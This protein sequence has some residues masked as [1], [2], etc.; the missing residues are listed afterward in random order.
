MTPLTL[1]LLSTLAAIGTFVVISATAVAA[2]IQLRHLRGSNQLVALNEI[3]EVVDSKEFAAAR[4]FVQHELP[5]LMRD[6]GFAE[7]LRAPLVDDTLHPLSLVGNL[8]ENLGTYVKY[9]IIDPD[10]ACD[11]LGGVVLSTWTSLYP[12]VIIRRQTT[13]NLSALWENFEYLAVLSED[14]AA[15]HPDGAY[16]KGVRRMRPPGSTQK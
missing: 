5:V 8:F 2:I 11:V 9:G 3:G 16:P 12:V 4:Q 15:R 6:P 13:E 1:E 7:R 10:I 14:F